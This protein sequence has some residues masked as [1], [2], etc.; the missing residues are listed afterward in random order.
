ML[1]SLVA[2]LVAVGSP[3]AAVMNLGLNPALLQ[4]YS[5]GV[6]VHC[7]IVEQLYLLRGAL[8]RQDEIKDKVEEHT[9]VMTYCGSQVIILRTAIC[10]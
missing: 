1:C 2:R 5:R 10:D 7:H 8:L 4:R 3:G 9:R 6:E